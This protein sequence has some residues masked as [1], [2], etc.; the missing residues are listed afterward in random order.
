M[1]NG[2]GLM[3][4]I[5]LLK[6]ARKLKNNDNGEVRIA[7]IG[8]Y[9]LQNFVSVLRYMLSQEQIEANIYEGFYNSIQYDVFRAHS[10]LFEFQPNYII[11]LTSTLDIKQQPQLFASKEEEKNCQCKVIEYYQSGWERLSQ[12]PGCQILQSNFVIPIIRQLGNLESNYTFSK[13]IFYQKLNIALV[14]HKRQ[15]VTILDMDNLASTVGKEKWFDYSAYCLSKAG[16]CLDY[17]GQVSELVVKQIKALMGK[18][19]KCLVLDLD[20]TLWGG[21][22]SEEGYNGIEINQYNAVG[23]SYYFFQQYILELKN[24]GVILAVCSKNDEEIAKEPFI[25]NKDMVLR[26]EDISCFVANWNDK[27]SNIRTIA[28]TLNIGIDSMVF[29]DDNPAERELVRQFLP[30]VC[31]IDVPE[32]SA[33]YAKALS[34]ASPFEWVQI[35]KEDV[36]RTQSYYQN[37]KRI[38]MEQNSV[39]YDSY[40]KALNMQGEVKRLC[41]A[42]VSRFTQLI[43]K[44]NQFNL[45]TQRYTQQTIEE[46]MTDNEKV[47]LS[48][49]LQDRFGDYGLISCIVLAK[50]EN[51]CFIDT[52]VMSCRVLKRGIEDLAIQNIVK[53]AKTMGCTKIIGEYI[54]TKKNDMVKGL[55]TQ[56]GFEPADRVEWLEQQEGGQFYQFDCADEV[57]KEIYIKT[58]E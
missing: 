3:D 45:R 37:Q 38:E 4:C 18:T 14:E 5:Q 26:L 44:S 29:F 54:P 2:K 1:E 52:W 55:Y 7:V 47:C 32:D 39:D 58:K 12:I 20:N 22:V 48:I 23:E 21:V 24:R 46:F 35:T 31:V 19:K 51:F 16:F 43:N 33:D 34:S 17:I 30:E 53:A 28:Q 9:S 8:S 56:L 42:D 10:E 13:T 57:K 25:H 49:K 41:E 40:L 15:N 27:V 50:K 11:I 36:E 6:K